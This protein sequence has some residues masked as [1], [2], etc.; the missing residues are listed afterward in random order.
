MERSQN[1]EQPMKR[2]SNIRS[3]PST[4]VGDVFSLI[5]CV[6]IRSGRV[7]DQT[8]KVYC[9]ICYVNHGTL[10]IAFYNV[11]KPS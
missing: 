11:A 8:L 7:C 3:I 2:G 9:M 4:Q 5:L 10:V 6:F 1:G